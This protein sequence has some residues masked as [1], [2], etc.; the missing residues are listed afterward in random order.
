MDI[1]HLTKSQF[2]MLVLLV[3]FVTS[4]ITGIVTV[5]LV[6]QTP[7]PLTER[8]NRVIEKTIEKVVP[9]AMQSDKKDDDNTGS[10]AVKIIDRE[11]LAVAVVEKA[12][13]AVVSV[14]ATKDLPVFEEY[15]INP[16]GDDPFF[17][18]FFPDSPL[19]VP[20][21]RQKGTETKQISSGTGFFV[22]EDGFLLTNKHV[23]ADVG[24]AYSVVTNNGQKF[25]AKVLARDPVQDFAVLKAE[26]ESEQKFNF[27]SLGDS[28]KIKV[29]QTV[30]A[31]GNVLGEFQNTVSLGVVSGLNR[32]IVASDGAG[33]TEQLQSVIQTDA[34]INPGNSGGPLLNL[35]GEV[36]GINTAMATNAENVGFAL[37]INFAKKGIAD[38]K[39]FGKIKYAYLGV[40][41]I[42]VNA[43]VKEEKKLSVDYGVML[44]KNEN[45][46][47][48]IIPGGPAEK[49]GLK[50]GDIIL[51]INGVKINKEDSFSQIISTKRVGETVGL[52]ILRG[53]DT[54]DIDIVLDERPETL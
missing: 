41:Y 3:S 18:Q 33:A 21:Y 9:Q 13:S 30:I 36:V 23:V 44:L 49:A 15:Y 48:A 28:S 12:S 37:Q 29:G 5:T 27:I 2:I 20:Q 8:V 25:S 11:E 43:G 26:P 31:I 38:V 34:A 52:K 6:N 24:A 40:R 7:A 19:S 16:F 35:K 32:T 17:K 10:G 46:E 45:G 22:S 47:P 54:L 50:E 53:V 51:E 39:E 4:L 1:D 14:I 42:A